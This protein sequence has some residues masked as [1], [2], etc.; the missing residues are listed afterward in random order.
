MWELNVWTWKRERVARNCKHRENFF[1]TWLYGPL[2]TLASL[3]RDANSSLLTAICRRLCTFVSHIFFTSSSCYL[4]LGLLLLL[5]PSDLLS[6]IFSNALPWS[7][8]STCS[9]HSNLFFIIRC[10]V[11]I[12]I[13]YNSLNSSLSLI[14]ILLALPLVHISF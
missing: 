14:T 7:I 2:R 1:I 3:I 8:L 9:I 11:Y 4:N 10:C 12:P 6:N 5:L 13:Q